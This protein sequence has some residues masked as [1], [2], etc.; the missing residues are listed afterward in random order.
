MEIQLS[1]T[2]RNGATSENTEEEGPDQIREEQWTL[3]QHCDM[4]RICVVPS[5]FGS[6]RIWSLIF[7][8]VWM[9]LIAVSSDPFIGMH[10]ISWMAKFL[11]LICF[12]DFI[13][14]RGFINVRSVPIIKAWWYVCGLSI[15]LLLKPGLYVESFYFF[16]K[17]RSMEKNLHELLFE[18]T[19]SIGPYNRRPMQALY[20][21]NGYAKR[22]GEA[23][24]IHFGRHE[25]NYTEPFGYVEQLNLIGN[26]FDYNGVNAVAE[27][28]D[29]PFSYT[30]SLLLGRNE[31]IE[32]NAALRLAK[33]I[34]SSKNKSK[35]GKLLTW[36]E[37]GGTTITKNGL[38]E[39]Y[40][41][42]GTR[43]FFYFGLQYLASSSV[44]K[45]LK[46]LRKAE[47]LQELSLAGNHLNDDHMP[48]LVE[49]VLKTNI[50]TLN[51]FNNEIGPTG[52][53]HLVPLTKHLTEL[54]LGM[55]RRIGDK[56]AA[57]LAKALKD[58]DA[59]LE[60]LFLKNCHVS[61]KEAEELLSIFPGTYL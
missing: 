32:D 43:S 29:H 12:F 3:I 41:A 36:L 16:K 51:L 18:N 24:S 11:C 25:L 60:T 26:L 54:N 37:V 49:E 7:F 52:V 38:A 2:D 20:I 46:H 21:G 40:R 1:V 42:M 10:V 14:Q 9:F 33:L 4:R 47:Y 45:S 31:Q 17:S 44:G 50:T 28:L 35:P 57:I 6:F 61:Q 59:T 5:W 34:E 56:G 19:S 30:E 58:P 39:L 8:L 22:L 15:L 55:N 23:L 48:V 13:R 27:A 53:E